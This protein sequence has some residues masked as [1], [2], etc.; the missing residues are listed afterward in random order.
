MPDHFLA[1]TANFLATLLV[2]KQLLLPVKQEIV[3]KLLKT[4]I[5]VYSKTRL[6]PLTSWA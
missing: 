5:K 6:K 3:I 4:S 2:A 1:Q